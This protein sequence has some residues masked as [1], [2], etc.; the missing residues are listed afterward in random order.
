MH[1]AINAHLLSP[2]A[3]YRQAGV[4]RYIEQ[5]LRRLLP[6]APLDRW[7]I[8]GPEG[9]APLIECTPRTRL[10]LSRLPTTHPLARIVWEQLA[11]PLILLRD[12]PAAM[13]CP[14]NVIPLATRT[15]A[16]V[17]VHDR[18]RGAVAGREAA[19][20]GVWLSETPV[21]LGA[22][23]CQEAPEVERAGLYLLKDVERKDPRADEWFASAANEW[24]VAA[25]LHTS[26]HLVVLV[27]A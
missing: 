14:L 27:P 22:M 18:H 13:F 11:A 17:C 8:Y 3:G 10:R 24:R 26:Q 23:G 25:T 4:S 7:T 6:A 9:I 15:P 1:L 21:L 2:V 16:V 12:Q 20:Q 19:T 5:L